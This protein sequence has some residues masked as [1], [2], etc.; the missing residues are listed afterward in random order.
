MNGR[1]MKSEPAVSFALLPRFHAVETV[2]HSQP[3]LW[4]VSAKS[5]P[6][7]R[8]SVGIPLVQDI[9]LY[10]TDQRVLLSGWVFR[11][12]RGDW[13]AWFAVEDA[14][15][16]RDRITAVSVGRAPLFG[17]YLQ[18]VTHNPVRH[19]WRSPETRVRLFIKNAEPLCRLL[20]AQLRTPGSERAASPGDARATGARRDR[21]PSVRHGSSGSYA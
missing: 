13:A 15:A 1:P 11:L 8:I 3:W 7:Y 6:S 21:S 14:A 5:L 19:W 9:S 16:D 20:Q 4:A 12:L 17:Q 18:V 2:L 10:V